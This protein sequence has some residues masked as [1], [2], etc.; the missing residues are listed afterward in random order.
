MFHNFF[1]DNELIGIS[2]KQIPSKDNAK[3]ETF[4]DFDIPKEDVYKYTDY[5]TT[6]KS[7]GIDFLYSDKS[8][9]VGTGD[10]KIIAG[11]LSARNFSVEKGWCVEIQGKAAR[12]GKACHGAINDVLKLNGIDTLPTSK[13]VLNA[14][15]INDEQYYDK[16]YYLVDR[17]IEN[18]SK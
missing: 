8:K 11:R 2:L 5:K 15:Q 16:L 1:D 13:D 17:F 14:F 7:S 18:I 3:S 9:E 6:L 12:G 4:N 10:T